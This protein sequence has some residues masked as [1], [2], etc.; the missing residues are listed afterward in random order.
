MD[1]LEELIW[2]SFRSP[3]G[4]YLQVSLWCF[5]ATIFLLLIRGDCNDGT[6]TFRVFSALPLW[7]TLRVSLAVFVLLFVYSHVG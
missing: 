3:V 4:D 2:Q 5:G 7:L 6:P 1:P